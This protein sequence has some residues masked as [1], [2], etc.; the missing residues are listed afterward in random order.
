MADDVLFSPL[1]FR[2]L[3][4]KNRIFRSNIAGRFDNYDGS[5][6]QGRINW[7]ASFARGGVGAIITSFTPVNMRGR[8]LPNYPT[9]DCDERIPF[10]RKVVREV[11]ALDCKYIIQLSHSGRQRDEGGIDNLEKI[12]LSSTNTHD[13]F[14]GIPCRAMTREEI[15]DSMEDFGRAARRAQ[16]A[17]AD[18]VE[19][20]GAN[21]YLITQFLSSAINDRT[22]EYGGSLENRARFVRGIVASIR[23]HAG[24]DFHLQMKINAYDHDNVI[25]INPFAK[26]GNNLDDTIRICRWLEADGV[27]AFHI[28]VGSL[29]PHPL[30]PPSPLGEAGFP[31]EFAARSYGAMLASGKD[32]FR[33][34]LLFRYRLL[35][36]IFHFIW[37]RLK[38]KY[39][40]VEGISADYARAIKKEVKVPVLCTGGFQ[41][42]AL[43]RDKIAHGYFDGVTIA[44]ALIA[45]RDLVKVWA[46]GRDLPERPCTHCNKC[47]VYAPSYPL[48]CYELARYGGDYDR[49]IREVYE[50]FDPP[51]SGLDER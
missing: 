38:K 16:E 39:P 44:R 10:W 46:S 12:A 9:I 30:N 43:I 19:L 20:H 21:G 1:K 35:R 26:Q 29:F 51:L 40:T 41:N 14:H 42:A 48:G 34:Y 37:N 24:Q 13:P 31:L 6:G 32:T 2:K 17:G 25:T 18:G 49:M 8:I 23:K 7:E 11:H 33:N 22:D 15:E 45:N 47:L 28:S 50:V 3:E 5:G 27:D 36:P 4:V